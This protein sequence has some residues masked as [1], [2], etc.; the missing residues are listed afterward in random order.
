MKEQ[1]EKDG[2][3]D[4]AA[5]DK[6]MCWC[7][8]NEDAKTEAISKAGTR[9]DELTSLIEELAAREA[10]L[11]TEIS[12]LAQDIADDQEALAAATAARQKEHAAFVAEEADLKETLALLKEAVGVLSKVQLVQQ[13]GSEPRIRTMLMQV[14]HR[15]RSSRPEYEN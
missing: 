6:F 9:I 10:Q 13:S 15:L 3:A 11:K 1:V 2:S 7:K 8:T 12:G 4:Q 5:Y 14:Q